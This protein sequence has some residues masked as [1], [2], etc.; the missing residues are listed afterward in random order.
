VNKNVNLRFFLDYRRQSPYVSNSY[1]VV[2]TQGGIT[3]RISL[4]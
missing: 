1:V 4:N 3:V 2:N